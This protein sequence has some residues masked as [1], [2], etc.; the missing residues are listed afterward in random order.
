MEMNVDESRRDDET[1]GVNNHGALCLEIGSNGRNDAIA[2]MNVPLP[3]EF[4]P[5]IQKTAAF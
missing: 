4:A 3:V 1:L 2:D 5:R